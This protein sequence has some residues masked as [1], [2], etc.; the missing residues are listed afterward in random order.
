MT[1]VDAPS[2][3]R[4]AFHD[5]FALSESTDRQRRAPGEEHQE[6]RRN[7]QNKSLVV[8]RYFPGLTSLSFVQTS[9]SPRISILILPPLLPRPGQR[10]SLFNPTLPAIGTTPAPTQKPPPPSSQEPLAAHH[11]RFWNVLSRAL[12]VIVCPPTRPTPPTWRNSML[13]VRLEM[14]G[15]IPN[16]CDRK[17]LH[18]RRG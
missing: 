11:C 15:V 16:R 2:G 3:S 12:V 7:I 6:K 4:L 14:P 8:F 9:P 1:P 13:Q 18:P 17:L 10:Q 5:L